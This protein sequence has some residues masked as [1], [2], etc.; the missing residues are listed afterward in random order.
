M[1]KEK[2]KKRRRLSLEEEAKTL[3]NILTYLRI[4]IV[5]FVVYLLW[6][7]DMESGFYA[8]L[9]YAAAAVTDYVD[10]FLARSYNQVTTVGKFLDP[11]AD[12]LLVISILVLMTVQ[13]KVPAWAVMLIIAREITIT[14]LRALAAAEGLIIAAEKLG[15]YKTAFQM[16]AL[17]GLMLHYEYAINMWF[18][19]AAID[20]HKVGLILLYISLIFSI[21]SAGDYF[22]G[23]IKAHRARI[24]AQREA[25]K[26]EESDEGEEETKAE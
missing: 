14:A 7:S 19:V 3:P 6:K 12:K 1:K 9:L 17:V 25:A 23:F 15:K 8:V 4:A 18:F 11:L 2:I 5:P 20:F 13:G 24:A 10:G 22:K 21:W 16:V 26:D